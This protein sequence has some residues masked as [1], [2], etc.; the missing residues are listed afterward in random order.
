MDLCLIGEAS[1]SWTSLS[2]WWAIAQMALGLGAVIFVHE[3]GHFLVAKACGVKCEKFYLGFDAFDIKIGRQVIVPRSLLKWTWGETQYGIGILPLGGYVK[4]LGQD[5]NPSNISAE[6]QR[7]QQ[8]EHRVTH[9]V[10]AGG[11][12]FEH[13]AVGPIDR[14]KLDP[15]S[16]QAKS[17]AQRMAI[18]SA[19]VIM[20]LIF[21]VIFATFA[22]RSGVN[23]LPPIIGQTTAGG[24]AYVA[25]VDGA[26]ILKINDMHVTSSYYTFEHLGMDI[27]LNGP[28]SP[29]ELTLRWPA[30][31]SDPSREATVR[32]TP[33]ININSQAPSLAA[34]GISPAL[35]TK[36]GRNSILPEQAIARAE[37]PIREQDKII[38]IDGEPVERLTDM[39]RIFSRIPSQPAR[40]TIE[41]PGKSP[42]DPAQIIEC[43]V[44]PN[45]IVELG[46]VAQTGPIRFVQQDSPA[47][48]AGLRTGDVLQTLNGEPIGDPLTLPDRLLDPAKSQSAVRLGVLRTD[49][50]GAQVTVEVAVAPRL[51]QF[52]N[53]YAMG[54]AS[55]DALG[56][57]LEVHDTVAAVYPG[58]P[59]EQAGFQPGDELTGANFLLNEEM[60]RNPLFGGE[61]E[62]KFKAPGIGWLNVF[63]NAQVIRPPQP[64]EFS[65]R[66]NGA[67]QKLTLTP[68]I[69]TRWFSAMRGMRPQYL[70]RTY[71]ARS[72]WEAIQLGAYQTRRDIGTV[73]TT[74]KKLVNGELSI[75]NLGG[76]GTIAAVATSEAS[77][78]SSRLLLFLTMLGANLA[79]LNF[80]PI[81]VLDGG[82]MMFLAYEG[83]FRRPV[84]ERIQIIL[85]FVG[86]FFIIGLMLLAISL[87]V[88]RFLL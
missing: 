79:I 75:T 40:V 67:T 37:P 41:R 57:A 83:I 1:F 8:G 53:H 36:L 18:I 10:S 19:G 56:L 21:S 5:D 64:I 74:L 43:T 73:L 26:E 15:R 55:I 69:S 7:S 38:A 46:I 48:A 3:L 65:V 45:P 34:L 39:R 86:L 59:A 60:R 52:G 30:K 33:A 11:L 78:G 22:F 31:G 4:M 66:R 32:L 47:A 54:L 23:Y 88:S 51:P 17:V 81:P 2:S 24:P 62:L 28:K 16:Y 25:N 71:R 63:E 35:T 9:E 68:Q 82:H 12:D 76:P 49:S 72:W 44:P 58:S 87:D 13:E 50:E 42:D 14:S 85:S 27:A 70:E 61:T 29:I 6:R 80:L 77:Q 20:N 84:N